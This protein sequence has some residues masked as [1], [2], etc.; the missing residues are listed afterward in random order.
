VDGDHDDDLPVTIYFLYVVLFNTAFI[1]IPGISPWPLS[2][3]MM[4]MMMY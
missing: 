4:M 2:M 1:A 3:V